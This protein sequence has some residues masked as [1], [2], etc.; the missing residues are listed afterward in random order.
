MVLALATCPPGRPAHQRLRRPVA[1][2]ARR[3]PGRL[4]LLGDR[5]DQRLDVAVGERSAAMA[6]GV[7]WNVCGTWSS[8]KKLSKPTS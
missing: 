2:G 1:D 8:M 3:D 4:P 6:P 7:S 5:L